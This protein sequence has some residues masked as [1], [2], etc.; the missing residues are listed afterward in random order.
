MSV[1]CSNYARITKELYLLFYTTLY[2]IPLLYIFL[3]VV[4]TEL[5]SYLGCLNSQHNLYPTT[6]EK[7]NCYRIIPRNLLNTNL[8]LKY[9]QFL[10]FS[11][12]LIEHSA[13]EFV[14]WKIQSI[15]I[16]LFIWFSII[17]SRLYLQCFKLLHWVSCC[18]YLILSRRL[19][20]SIVCGNN[21]KRVADFLSSL[22][23]FNVIMPSR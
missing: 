19:A 8:L 12:L 17:L 3:C 6:T 23:S 20:A 13:F 22:F 15:F 2:I 14:N 4:R 9:K 5:F 1:Q 21:L 18:I 7:E 10:L 11:H 16:L